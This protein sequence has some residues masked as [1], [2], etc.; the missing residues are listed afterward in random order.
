MNHKHVK[1]FVEIQIKEEK[2][3]QRTDQTRQGG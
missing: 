3:Q 2:D 1:N